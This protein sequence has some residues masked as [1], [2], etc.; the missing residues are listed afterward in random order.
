MTAQTLDTHPLVAAVAGL[1]AEL[2]RMDPAAWAGLGRGD[3]S[4]VGE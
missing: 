1:H 2:D 4:A 3:R